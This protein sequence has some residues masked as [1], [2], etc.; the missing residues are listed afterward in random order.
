MKKRVIYSEVPSREEHAC[1]DYSDFLSTLLSIFYVINR[2]STLT[3]EYGLVN[4]QAGWHFPR[5]FHS[6]RLLGTSEYGFSS[7]LHPIKMHFFE[8]AIF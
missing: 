3:S 6:D 2:K 4:K 1:L 5:L 7:L 8:N